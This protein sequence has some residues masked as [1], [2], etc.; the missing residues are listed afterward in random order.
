MTNEQRVNA[1]GLF[2][3]FVMLVS[4]VFMQGCSFK[5]ETLYH[6]QT[7][8]GIDDRKATV[9]RAAPAAQVRTVKLKDED[10]D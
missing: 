2:F 3:I 7:P 10:R 5:I 1:V 4:G 6:G 9:M 8:V